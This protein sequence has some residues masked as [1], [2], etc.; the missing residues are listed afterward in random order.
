MWAKRRQEV[1]KIEAALK[2]GQGPVDLQA[3]GQQQDVGEEGSSN[4]ADEEEGGSGGGGKAKKRG[5]A[6]GGSGEGRE[7]RRLRDPASGSSASGEGRSRRLPRQR[8][9]LL[10]ADAAADPEQAA[11][12]ANASEPITVQHIHQVAEAA[13]EPVAADA[14][15]EG[16]EEAAEVDRDD[17][18]RRAALAA[19]PPIVKRVRLCWCCS[20][21]AAA[22]CAAGC[23]GLLLSAAAAALTDTAN[24]LHLAALFPLRA[25]PARVAF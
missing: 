9:A 4:A 17:A 25:R 16:S 2:G 14:S 11:A 10:E 20:L 21:A 1:A 22:G 18:E 3:K 15:A 6:S 19:M 23:P 8:R 13:D 5:L 7:R 12:A 24:V